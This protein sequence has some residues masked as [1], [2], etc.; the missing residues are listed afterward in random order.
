MSGVMLK[1]AA[2]REGSSWD[3]FRA[4]MMGAV[5]AGWVRTELIAN[6]AGCVWTSLA[7][8]TNRFAISK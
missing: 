7:K 5:I 4:P 2:A 8:L 6:V 3:T 1:S